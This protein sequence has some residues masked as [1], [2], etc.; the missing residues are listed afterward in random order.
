M[1]TLVSQSSTVGAIRREVGSNRGSRP[2]RQA[3]VA[4]LVYR[5]VER[6][7]DACLIY[8]H[9]TPPSKA[10]AEPIADI[11]RQTRNIDGKDERDKPCNP[12][13]TQLEPDVENRNS[14]QRNANT[15]G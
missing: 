6:R 9:S 12:P 11:K 1:K 10:P 8:C 15:D 3:V 2:T 7:R 4:I 13:P 5:R 14:D